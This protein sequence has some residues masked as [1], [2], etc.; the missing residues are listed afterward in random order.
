MLPCHLSEINELNPNPFFSMSLDFKDTKNLL[1]PELVSSQY[2]H[3]HY[4]TIDNND[5]TYK[6]NLTR[7]DAIS[8]FVEDVSQYKSHIDWLIPHFNP[9]YLPYYFV[10][11]A[12][13]MICLNDNWS[14]L[15]WVNHFLHELSLTK[16]HNDSL[17]LIHYDS[18]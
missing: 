6:V 18:H 13:S 1:T 16:Q 3:D 17:I 9:I 4:F 11:D 5:N 8:Y 2:F 10:Y 7:T 12:R 14:L 15:G